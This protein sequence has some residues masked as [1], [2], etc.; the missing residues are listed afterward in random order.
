MESIP[1][2]VNRF[3]KNHIL[4]LKRGRVT[5]FIVLVIIVA[6][7]G[8]TLWGSAAIGSSRQFRLLALPAPIVMSWMVWLFAS[9]KYPS[10]YMLIAFLAF[11]A[12]F[13]LGKFIIFSH[14]YSFLP[15][16]TGAA[17]A[18]N[19]E[20][21]FAYYPY[22]FHSTHWK[23]MLSEWDKVIDN[24]DLI[25]ILAAPFAIYKYRWWQ[26]G[27]NGPGEQKNR[28]YIKRRFNN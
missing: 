16:Y 1:A 24:Q 10:K 17:Y 19:L 22:L 21:V 23:I 3:L 15:G 25:Y 8:A 28:K 20:A 4:T 9:E 7:F 14:F 18:D 26:G 6:F 13:F 12:S 5:L 11:L 27:N 2:Q